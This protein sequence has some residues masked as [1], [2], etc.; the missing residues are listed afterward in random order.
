M[1]RQEIVVKDNLL[2]I[3]IP[4]SIHGFEYLTTAILLY[5]NEVVLAGT[6]GLYAAIALRY[7]TTASRVERAMRHAIAGSTYAGMPNREFIA[8]FH[9][10]LRRAEALAQ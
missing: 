10:K 3:G 4:P 6:K 9:Y 5:S 7:N 1:T 2:E 8:T